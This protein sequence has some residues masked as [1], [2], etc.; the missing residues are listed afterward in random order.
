LTIFKLSIYSCVL[1][2]VN[3]ELITACQH[4]EAVNILRNAGDIVMLT[5][6]HYR[7]A[8]PFLQKTSETFT[9]LIDNSPTWIIETQISIRMGKFTFHFSWFTKGYDW[10][11]FL[12]KKIHFPSRHWTP[13]YKI[14]LYPINLCETNGFANNRRINEVKLIQQ[15]SIY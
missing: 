12:K 10:I 9:L 7:A 11:F 6:K 2:P 14:V 5:V 1:I 8:T 4:D 3:G 13:T 15:F